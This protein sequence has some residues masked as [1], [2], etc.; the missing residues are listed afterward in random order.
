MP[1]LSMPAP[2]EPATSTTRGRPTR[3]RPS[4]LP[5]RLWGPSTLRRLRAGSSMTGLLVPVL[6]L[7]ERRDGGVRLRLCLL[8]R[9]SDS[10]WSHADRSSDSRRLL[11]SDSGPSR[12]P[13]R[14]SLP[15]AVKPRPVSA[16]G[17]MPAWGDGPGPGR[18]EPPGVRDMRRPGG[19]VMTPG[20][21]AA[22]NAICGGDKSRWTA[23]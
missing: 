14:D 5:R 4:R 22:L 7:L 19:P 17:T 21:A 18:I 6:P 9:S 3:L 16:A 13:S 2:I 11:D 8:S 23:I 15:W 12:P 10:R 1:G 20:A